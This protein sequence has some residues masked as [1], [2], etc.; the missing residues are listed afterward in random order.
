[1]LPAAF[2][3]RFRTLLRTRLRAAQDARAGRHVTDRPGRSRADESLLDFSL[4]HRR[5]VVLLL[6]H[7]EGTPYEA[8]GDEV[9][10]EL[11]AAALAHFA[12]S[13]P[14]EAGDPTRTLVLEQIYRNY[15]HSLVGLLQQLD[16][17]EPIRRAVAAYE[18]Y[19]LVG[20]RGFFG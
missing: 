6:G 8:V 9:V 19:H 3:T 13:S 10:A 5:R 11:A 2:V 7:G 12:P 14:A 4:R 20:L 17:P 18:R 16:E 15:V 1:M